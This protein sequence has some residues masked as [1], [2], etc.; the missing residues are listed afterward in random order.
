MKSFLIICLSSLLFVSCTSVDDEPTLN[1]PFDENSDSYFPVEI[2]SISNIDLVDTVSL[3]DTVSFTGAVKGSGN[4]EVDSIRADISIINSSGELDFFRTI[5]VAVDSIA[6]VLATSFASTGSYMLEFFA[7]NH[8]G[9][10]SDSS[11]K[12]TITVL[13]F[14][15]KVNLT[16]DTIVTIVAKNIELTAIG[17]DINVG[18]VVESFHW[19]IGDLD[20]TTNAENSKSTIALSFGEMKT[21]WIFVE[22]IDDDGISSHKDSAFVIIGD[23]KPVLNSIASFATGLNGSD[24]LKAVAFDD[25]EIV[26]YLWKVDGD[27]LGVTTT[28]AIFAGISFSNT[29]IHTVSVQAFD[30]E[31]NGSNIETVTITVSDKAPSVELS[32]DTLITLE[33]TAV[34]TAAV[35]NGGSAPIFHWYLNGELQDDTTSASFRFVPVTAGYDTISLVL[36]NDENLSSKSVEWIVHSYEKGRPVIETGIGDT[37]VG[38]SENVAITFAA[39]DENITELNYRWSLN[40][41]NNYTEEGK[42]ASFTRLDS[43][44]LNVVWIAEDSDGNRSEPDSFTITFNKA[45]T[46]LVVSTTVLSKDGTIEW[47]CIDEDVSGISF[48]LFYGIV[49]DS[50]SEK[51]TGTNTSYPPT[52]IVG[53]STIY[54]SLVAEDSDGATAEAT[55]SLTTGW[56][57]ES[58]DNDD[59]TTA[60]EVLLNTTFYG[61]IGIGDDEQDWFTFVPESN[62]YFQFQVSNLNPIGT[63]SSSIGAIRL[64][65]KTDKARSIGYQANCIAGTDTLF[66]KFPL[67]K[68][69]QYFLK[70]EKYTLDHNAPYSVRTFYTTT[71][72]EDNY[73]ENDLFVTADTIPLQTT[74]EATIGLDD[75]NDYY[76]LSPQSSGTFTFTVENLN[77]NGTYLGGMISSVRL[78]QVGNQ[79]SEKALGSI[80]NNT[81]VSSGSIA[82]SADYI[83][84]LQVLNGA[85]HY[86]PYRITTEF[87]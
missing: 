45:P 13:E 67:K 37:T 14:A 59:S 34:V 41:T 12:E 8:L 54:Y 74:I 29:G 4:G 85:T 43:A 40:G 39:T 57:E 51:Y 16:P 33:D 7:V 73:E 2:L 55:G 69:L 23:G 49:E 44:T 24:T 18:G 46:E 31:G 76:I 72:H 28:D 60:D 3:F 71:S 38:K 27:E 10:P 5:S 19:T 48:T 36:T 77:S 11:I 56:F 47:S 62:G 35:S 64:F 15:P 87:Q 17:S 68:G 75:S 32:G 52:D 78:Y 82:L 42:S 83:Y 9:V 81:T 63:P 20:T 30:D 84:Y 58:D 80:A 66:K 70:V 21:L 79:V 22:A 86:A 25:S 65:V 53:G 1:N 61:E 26:S 6:P 50:L